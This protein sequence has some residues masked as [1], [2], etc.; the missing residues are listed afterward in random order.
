MHSQ[1]DDT[2]R[3]KEQ[4]ERLTYQM[5]DE[6]R[7]L[8]SRVDSQSMD[9]STTAAELKNKSRRLEEDNRQHVS[10]LLNHISCCTVGY[11]SNVQPVDFVKWQSLAAEKIGHIREWSLVRGKLKLF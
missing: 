3:A 10:E 9:F 6:I 5:A 8:K 1:L 4:L 2:V 7:Q 11:I